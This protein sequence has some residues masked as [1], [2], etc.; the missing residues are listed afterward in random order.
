MTESNIYFDI[1]EAARQS[2]MDHQLN[3]DSIVP[4][5]VGEPGIGKTQTIMAYA[6]S[7]NYKVDTIILGRIPPVDI[8]G[9]YA[10]DF[11]RREL[12]HFMT[13]RLIGGSAFPPDH[14]GLIVFFDEIGSAQDDTQVAIQSLLQ[15]MELDGHKVDR[16]VMFVC[17]TNLPEHTGGA[18]DLVA[19]LR[20]RLLFV[21]FKFDMNSWF[22]MARTE[23]NILPEVYSYNLWR[24]GKHLLGENNAISRELSN[25]DPRGWNKA[26]YGLR[27]AMKAKECETV[28]ELYSGHEQLVRAIMKG[29]VGEAMSQEFCGFLKAQGTLPTVREVLSDPESASVPVGSCEQ[30]A[31]IY[32]LEHAMCKLAKAGRIPSDNIESVYTYIR[33]L[34][35]SMTMLAFKQITKSVDQFCKHR[36][37]NE[38]REDFASS[39]VVGGVK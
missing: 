18:N 32:N 26:N 13:K 16:R 1:L 22:L 21:D 11:T 30:Y 9:I 36:C 39:M 17:A 6:K 23:W 35:K 2:Q 34:P 10:P 5:F 33:R 24:D 15:E 19:S 3:R 27:G 14:D 28:Y 7:I 20:S 37:F 4:C 31:I 25:P 29:Q 12:I 38:F 8:G